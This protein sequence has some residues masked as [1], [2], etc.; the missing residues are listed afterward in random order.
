[1]KPTFIKI[2]IVFITMIY[3]SHSFSQ[4][5]YHLVKKIELPGNGSWDYLKID[6]DNRLYVSHGDR[7]HVINLNTCKEIKEIKNLHSAKHIVLLK[8]FNKG[9]ISNA[10]NNTVQVFNYTTMDSIAAINVHGESPDPICYDEFS[11]K[12][13]VF[14]D[15]NIAS[16]IDPVSNKEIS[17]INL[18]GAPEFPLPDNK[19][20]IYNN[21]EDKDAVEVID[22]EMK[23]VTKIYKLKKDA[24]PTGM[25]ADLKNDRLFVACRG[26]NELAILDSKSG[27]IIASLPT[28]E[29]VDGVYFDEKNKYIFCSGGDG[30][31]TIIVQKSKNDYAVLQKLSTRIGAKTMALDKGTHNLYLTTA[32]FEK[33]RIKPNSFA[34]YIYA[35]KSTF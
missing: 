7:V 32:D 6:N 11:K 8:Q 19:G 31:V 17:T 2:L 20:I 4:S 9:F 29:K 10:E 26:I 14:C 15:N 30:F 23:Q 3:G 25:A 12:L 1:M 21:L 35:Q 34:L 22:L 27:K 13:Y 28:S 33:D 24:A 18:Q 16:I 5:G